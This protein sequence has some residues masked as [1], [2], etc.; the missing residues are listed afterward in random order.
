MDLSTHLVHTQMIRA[1]LDSPESARRRELLFW[2]EL[3]QRELRR[4]RRRELPHRIDALD[5]QEAVR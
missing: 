2:H 3:E 5:A 1:S 4:R